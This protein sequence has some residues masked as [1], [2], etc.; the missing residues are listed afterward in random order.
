MAGEDSRGQAWSGKASQARHGG[1]RH[2]WERRGPVGCELARQAWHGQAWRGKSRNGKAGNMKRTP[3]QIE[4]ARLTKE[5]G[6][7]LAPEV[8]VE[9]AKD[10][11]TALHSQ[12]NWDDTEAAHL[13]RLHQARNL[14]RV[15]VYHEPQVERTTQVYVSLPE[16]RESGGGYRR[17]VDVLSDEDKRRQLLAM[18]IA[19]L[20]VFQKKYQ[21]LNE[22]S[23][24]FVAAKKAAKRAKARKL[25]VAK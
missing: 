14:I 16:D 24:V 10:E 3:I 13:Y 9:F 1:E 20:E 5:H 6:G 19:E 22:L 11:S 15:Q 4:L 7:I 23:E 21:R 25:A 8:V 2:A 18:A 12:F 17:M